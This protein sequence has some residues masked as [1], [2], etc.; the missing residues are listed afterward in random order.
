MFGA[1]HV[2]KRIGLSLMLGDTRVIGRTHPVTQVGD[3]S[4]QGEK[5]DIA[6]FLE[7]ARG[8]CGIVLAAVPLR[9]R[10]RPYPST[11]CG[12]CL[13]YGGMDQVFVFDAE[14]GMIEY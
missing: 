6:E 7:V 8:P 10:D 1:R 14:I 2:G 11:L 3:L 5:A 4:L 13:R 12:H 9:Y